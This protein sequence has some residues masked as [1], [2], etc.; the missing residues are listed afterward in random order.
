MFKPGFYSPRKVLKITVRKKFPVKLAGKFRVLIIISLGLSL[1]YKYQFSERKL[2]NKVLLLKRL[3][4][5]LLN[6]YKQIDARSLN[7]CIVQAGSTLKIYVL[8]MA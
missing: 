5:L 3:S 6:I 7:I 1:G 8:L 2:R 4:K